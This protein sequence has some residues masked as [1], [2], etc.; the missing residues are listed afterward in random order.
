VEISRHF[1]DLLVIVSTYIERRGYNHEAMSRMR[2]I[3]K[4]YAGSL[5]R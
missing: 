4:K 2:S 3:K 1:K 5:L